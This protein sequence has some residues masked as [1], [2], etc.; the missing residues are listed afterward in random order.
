MEIKTFNIIINNTKKEMEKSLKYLQEYSSQVRSGKISLNILDKVQIKNYG[1][2]VFL[3]QIAN[4]FILD[5]IT[6]TIQPWEL[7]LLPTIEKAIINSNLGFT[8]INNG[9]SLLVRLPILT[10]EG[11]RELIKKV[12]IE[13]EQ[14]K[15]CIRNIRKEAN[16]SFKKIEGLSKDIIKDME[17]HIQKITDEYI[18]KIDKLYSF[19]EKEIMII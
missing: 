15:I 9:E 5:S 7:A 16:N 2:I 4:I 18:K 19:K 8:P 11:R 17:K 10:E 12:K 3:N 6:L 13:F 14:T 1:K